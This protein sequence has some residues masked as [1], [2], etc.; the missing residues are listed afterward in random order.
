M[1]E[2]RLKPNHYYSDLYDRHTVDHCRR[3][4]RLWEEN[5]TEFPEDAEVTE[6]QKEAVRSFGKEWHLRN[7]MGERHLKKSETIREWTDRDQ[8]SD[9]LYESAQPPKDIRCL[10]CRNRLSVTFKDLWSQD[11]KEER[12]LF[13]FDCPNNCLPRRAFFSDGEEWRTKPDLCPKCSAPL[14]L[15]SHE[16]DGTKSV[17]VQACTK[18]DHTKKDEF[19][20]SRKEDD[21]DLDFA[22]DRDRFCMTDDEGK[23]YQEEKW[24]MQQLGNLMKEWDE[25]QKRRDER[26]KENPKG[27]H[28]D[29]VGYRCAICGDSTPEGDNWYDEYGIKCLV[30]QKAVDEGEVPASVAKDTGSWYSKYD[31]ESCFNVKSPTLRKWVKEGIVKPRT[32][33]HYG[34]GTHYEM[35]LIEDNKDF[36]PPKKL[37]ES[38]SVSEKHEDGTT[39]HKSH[40]WYHFVDP[41]EHLKGY[42]IMNHLRVLTPEEV[43]EREAEQKKKDEE[44]EAKR[45]ARRQKKPKK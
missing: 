19:E 27:F 8:K 29:G 6:R 10:T 40:P 3:I 15:E 42:K 14:K 38:H 24:N 37:V 2:K 39:W 41:A 26:L 30:C 22:A 4:E 35:F 43:A 11:G 36:L 12:V 18:C 23:K 9:D 17:T 13:M 25:E 21:I 44:K 31:F 45:I 33:S 34:N 5:D 32:V 20:W 28:L 7:M 16:D 1:K